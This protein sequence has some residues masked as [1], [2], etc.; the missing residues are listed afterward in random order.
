MK[1]RFP[2]PNF[3]GVE[4]QENR[5]LAATTES[6]VLSHDISL[7]N[8]TGCIGSLYGIELPGSITFT[9]LQFREL[10]HVKIEE[11]E[12]KQSW[13]LQWGNSR[14]PLEVEQ[15]TKGAE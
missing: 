4:K 3:S 15:P 8:T 9:R 1:T 12:V 5:E 10:P 14:I 11:R 7:H 13:E 2:F 6:L